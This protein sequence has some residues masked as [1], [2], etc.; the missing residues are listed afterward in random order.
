MGQISLPFVEPV[1]EDQDGFLDDADYYAPTIASFMSDVT[2]IGLWIDTSTAG[3]EGT[4]EWWRRI[5]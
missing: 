1:F 4:F 3:I 5:S 2:G